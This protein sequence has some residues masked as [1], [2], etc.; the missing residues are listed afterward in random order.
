MPLLRLSMVSRAQVGLGRVLGLSPNMQMY[1]AAHVGGQLLGG[2]NWV[3]SRARE[4]F[5][6]LSNN[7]TELKQSPMFS[8]VQS[9]RFGY[10][11]RRLGIHLVRCPF[12]GGGPRKSRSGRRAKY[13]W[14]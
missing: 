4:G 3:Q 1:K 12:F 5:V 9:F 6:P 14:T 11:E 2:S 8:K 10:L 7:N 13:P